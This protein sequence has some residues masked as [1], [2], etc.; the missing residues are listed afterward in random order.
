MKV[1]EIIGSVVE[2]IIKLGVLIFLVTL[3]Y[4]G[5]LTAY[6]YGYRVFTEAPVSV[7]EGRII[8]VEIKEDQSAMEIGEMLLQKGLIRDARIFFLQELL[9]EYRGKE[10]PGIYDLSTAMTGAEMLAVIC[11]DEE[12]EDL[13][14]DKYIPEAASDME[15][16]P[17]EGQEELE[18]ISEDDTLNELN[19]VTE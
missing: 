14:E 8:S 15:E 9:S 13:S 6:D 16:L 7:G 19:E 12:E 3:I 5:A 10:V 17:E 2:L 1:G 4:K 11:P 18:I